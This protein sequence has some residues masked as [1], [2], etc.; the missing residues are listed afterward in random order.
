MAAINWRQHVQTVA[1][2]ASAGCEKEFIS[3]VPMKHVLK[4]ENGA[5]GLGLGTTRTM[6]FTS[7]TILLSNFFLTIA[8]NCISPVGTES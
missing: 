4:A 3:K 2:V 6:V 8:L 5:V 7:V 1:R